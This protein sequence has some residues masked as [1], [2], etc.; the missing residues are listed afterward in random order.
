MKK[1]IILLLIIF[2]A[3]VLFAQQNSSAP[4]K[5]ALVMGNGNYNGISKLTNPVNDANDMETALRNLGFTVEKVLNGNLDEMETA[6]LN[7]KRKLGGMRHSYG[8]FFYAGHGVQSNGENYLIPVDA[9]NIR[10]E[11]QLR[12]RAVSIQFV[13]DTLNEAGNELN[14]V[15]LDACRDNPFGWARSGSRGLSVISQTPSGTIVMYAAGAGQQA[16]DGAGKRNGLFTGYLLNNL[17]VDGY[18]VFDVFDKTMANVINETNGKQHPEL[19]LRFAGASSAY[20]GSS[21]AKDPAPAP[22]LA[23]TTVQPP[24]QVQKQQPVANAIPQYDKPYENYTHGQ[25]W[26]TFWLNCLVPGLGNYVIT[27]DVKPGVWNTILGGT[28]IILSMVGLNLMSSNPKYRIDEWDYQELTDAYYTGQVLGIIGAV[29]SAP[30]L[31]HNIIS[32]AA[33]DRP[34]T[35]ISLADP[36]A[37]QIAIV[38]GGNGI[39]ALS[40]S[41]TLRF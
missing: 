30:F 2:T 38:P 21:P 23:Q 39:E 13:L 1:A 34:D 17:K 35:R 22:V 7:F 3:S 20:L 10:S 8:F 41:Y 36:D 15:V 27:K 4:Q 9:D 37:W 5:F 16:S 19:S 28:S 12:S 40:L 6:V 11:T 18:S 31:I 33:R 26:G 32:S 25:R 29:F 24:S 14:M